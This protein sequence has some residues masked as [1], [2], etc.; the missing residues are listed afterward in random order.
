MLVP[1][2]AFQETLNAKSMESAD[3]GVC[4][5]GPSGCEEALRALAPTMT[6]VTDQ[7]PEP[8]G[9]SPCVFRIHL[10][11]KQILNYLSNK[12]NTA[13]QDLG[14]GK[15]DQVLFVSQKHIQALTVF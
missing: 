14:W 8:E 10:M 5:S 13:P 15:I 6:S 2:P 7:K 3:S 4:S 11:D 9:L 1:G 12:E